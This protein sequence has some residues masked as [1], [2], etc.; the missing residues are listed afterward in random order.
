MRNFL[1]ICSMLL[2]SIQIA[3]AQN[4][5]VA[6]TLT[7][8]NQSP[9]PRATVMLINASDSTMEKFT[10]SDNEGKFAFNKLKAGEFLLQVSYVGYQNISRPISLEVGKILDIGN[11]SMQQE[12]ELL[13]NV[14][15]EAD[16]IPMQIKE[17]TVEYNA[18]AFDTRPGATVEDLLKK[19]PG[20]EVEN[21]G[22]IKAQGETINKVLVD[23]KEF[24]GDDPQIATKN[25]PADAMDKVQVFDQLSEMSQFTGVDDGTREKTINLTLKE[26]KKN[27]LFGNA[28]GGYGENDRYNAKLNLNQFT[29]KQQLSVISSA[30]NINQQNFSLDDYINLSGGLSNLISGGG[31]SISLE[32]DEGLGSALGLTNGGIRNNWTVGANFN[33]DI[34]DKTEL[35]FNYFFNDLQNVLNKSTER[36]NFNGDNVFLSNS[37]SANES[38]YNLHR[39][40]FRLKHEIDDKQDITIRNSIKYTTNETISNRTSANFDA[41]G[42]QQTSNEI[43]DNSETDGLQLEGSIQYRKKFERKGRSLTARLSGEAASNDNLQLLNSISNILGAENPI[44]TIVNQEQI[45]DNNR[46]KWGT[47]LTYTEPVFNGKLLQGFVE[48]QQTNFILNKDFFDLEQDNSKVL[49]ETLSAAFDNQYRYSTGGFRLF[50]GSK[51]NR[52]TLGIKAQQ[53]II[54]GDASNVEDILTRRFFDFLPSARWNLKLKQ[55]SN[56]SVDYTTGIQAPSLEQLQP[57]VNNT[58]PLYIYNGNPNLDREYA[59]RLNLNYNLFDQFSLTSLFIRSGISYVENK[60]TN[61]SVIDELF[62]QVVTPVNVA[63]DLGINNNISFSTPLR[64]MKAKI[65]LNLSSNYNRGLLFVNNSENTVDRI[66]N[67]ADIKLENRRKK[68]I[69]TGVGLR[70]TKNTTRYLTESNLDQDF[71]QQSIYATLN[72]YIKK[73]WSIGGEFS[74]ENFSGDSFSN[75]Q[76]FP[77]LQAY[78]SRTFLKLDRA[79]LKISAFDLL[80]RN[81][82]IFRNSNFNFITDETVNVLN[83]YFMVSFR[84]KISKF[85]A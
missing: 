24:F 42:N 20:V 65:N 85:K 44:T 60:I 26:D 3:L 63:R 11:V 13:E 36:Q 16:R 31:G 25:L 14:T 41:A 70:L 17:D 32:L 49:N 71:L 73:K 5:G 76:S 21:D 51:K 10:I 81:Q 38:N 35:S 29:K 1:L 28:E 72:V 19:L 59:H 68:M 6:G 2:L 40:N 30:N 52:I 12:N 37:Q 50:L 74:Q 79:E 23:G 8:E 83:R 9:L 58:N 64:W 7:D 39:L 55:G 45:E 47:R 18:G 67:T 54:R 15:I 80:N 43:A 46:K 78:I 69:D 84:Y 57:V 27:G 77:L 4:S 61:Q 75:N 82:G 53:S 34:S 22:T 56:L 33:K 48:H 62:R 66:I